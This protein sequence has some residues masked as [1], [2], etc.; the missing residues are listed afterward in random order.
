LGP[1]NSIEVNGSLRW[2]SSDP[3]YA[4]QEVA[5]SHEPEASFAIKGKAGT[6]RLIASR[7]LPGASKAGS[8]KMQ[9]AFL[10][11]DV[12]SIKRAPVGKE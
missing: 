8:E 2:D 7:K 11:E 5:D 12:V 3:F 6:V 10:G 4:R 1:D 9:V